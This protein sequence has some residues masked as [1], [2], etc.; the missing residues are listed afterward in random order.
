[1]HHQALLC[2]MAV[3]LLEDRPSGPKRIEQ[4]KEL[5]QRCRI[6]SRLAR[7]FDTDSSDNHM[8]RIR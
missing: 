6:W 1:M 4:A 2:K 3:E 8:R 7:Q 5:Q